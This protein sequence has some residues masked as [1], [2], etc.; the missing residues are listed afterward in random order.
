[1][2]LGSENCTPCHHVQA[3]VSTW[4]S[5]RAWM[6]LCSSCVFL[7]FHYINGAAPSAFTPTLNVTSPQPN[8]SEALFAAEYA[9][10]LRLWSQVSSLSCFINALLLFVVFSCLFL[11]RLWRRAP[12]ATNLK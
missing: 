12:Y 7:F 10:N 5:V 1:M 2:T 4:V 8:Y 11:L 3:S 6:Y 9:L